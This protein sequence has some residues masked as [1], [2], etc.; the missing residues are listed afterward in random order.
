M[1]AEILNDLVAE[2]T[3]ILAPFFAVFAIAIAILIALIG[4]KYYRQ[5]VFLENPQSERFDK[6]YYANAHNYDTKQDAARDYLK[7][8]KLANEYEYLYARRDRARDLYYE[9]KDAYKFI[10]ALDNM[11]IHIDEP[12]ELDDD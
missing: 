4:F 7:F 8:V 6:F 10:K 5:A 9:R 11:D 1:L 2:F 12:F 3:A